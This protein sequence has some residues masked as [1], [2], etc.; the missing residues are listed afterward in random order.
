MIK[1]NALLSPTNEEKLQIGE[2]LYNN[3]D[4]FIMNTFMWL[5]ESRNWW[6]EFPIHIMYDEYDTPNPVTGAKRDIVAV[7][8]F[9]THT[10]GLGVLKTY[11]IATS[12]N[13]RGFGYAKKLIKQAVLLNMYFD[14]N[15][16]KHCNTY[17][18]N[19]DI[20]SDGCAFFANWLGQINSTKVDNEF[21][22]TDIEFR[23]DSVK[24]LK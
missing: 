11:Y 21:G 4:G 18:V 17:F 2:W 13:H 19:S 22:S 24:L 16:E 1:T 7:H 12:K 15:H 20:N 14:H 8:A 10:K 5:W 3:T 23:V 9:T 6:E